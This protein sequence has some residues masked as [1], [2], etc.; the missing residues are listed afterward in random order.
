MDNNILNSNKMKQ[1]IKATIQIDETMKIKDILKQ[2]INRTPISVQFIQTKKVDP[3]KTMLI[4]PC[5][6]ANE[7]DEKGKE[8][9]ETWL[10]FCNIGTTILDTGT[11]ALTR[12]GV[13]HNRDGVHDIIKAFKQLGG[14][15]NGNENY[16]K[17]QREIDDF[18]YMFLTCG[19]DKQNRIIKSAKSIWNKKY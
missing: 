17:K 10:A 11:R 2:P 16:N 12:M 13:I 8:Q 4:K 15:F 1:P 19:E 7:F 9:I 3:F 18:M 5:K 6:T 14:Y